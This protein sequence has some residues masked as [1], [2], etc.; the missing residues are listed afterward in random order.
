[1]GGVEFVFEIP[2]D[3]TRMDRLPK[4]EDGQTELR[5]DSGQMTCALH[6]QS[7]LLSSTIYHLLIYHLFVLLLLHATVDNIIGSLGKI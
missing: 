4:L 7:A 2:T 1:M 5:M 3:I 6:G